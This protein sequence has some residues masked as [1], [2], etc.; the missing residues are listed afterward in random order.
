MK[1]Y[2]FEET[3]NI[4]F[5]GGLKDDNSLLLT[6]LQDGFSNGVET[7]PHPKEIERLERLNKRKGKKGIFTGL[8]PKSFTTMGD[9]RYNSSIIVVSGGCGFGTKDDSYFIDLFKKLNELLEK[10]NSH[11][12]FVRG[13]NDDPSYFTDDKFSFSNIHL[14]EDYSI[15]KMKGFNCLCIGGSIPVDRQW[16]IEQSER[17][18]RKLFFEKCPTEFN[19]ETFEE[20]LN[21]NDFSCVITSDSPTFI[22]SSLDNVGKSRWASNDKAIVSD[23]T[24][25]RLVFDK[26]YSEFVRLDK[27]PMLWCMSTP[28]DDNITF[29]NNIR[30]ISSS[31]VINMYHL[32]D[33]CEESFGVWLDGKKHEKK[34]MSRKIKPHNTWTTYQSAYN[35]AIAT[36]PIEHRHTVETEELDGG[37]PLDPIHTINQMNPEE[38][39]AMVRRE[40]ELLSQEVNNRRGLLYEA[41]D[42]GAYPIVDYRDLGQQLLY[43]DDVQGRAVEE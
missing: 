29:V 34:K 17:L 15:L 9:G 3:C 11:I 37:E 21:N 2:N 19:K 5:A 41:P 30:F 38:L 7:E 6:K 24:N 31:S 14:V 32:N 13:N 1:T 35:T 36:E 25:Q 43:T 39:A 42:L 23:I 33:Q 18:G 20:I 40:Q 8:S 26:I 27:K 10:N 22:S 12:V 16:K 28:S 4:F